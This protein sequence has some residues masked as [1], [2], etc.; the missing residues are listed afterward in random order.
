MHATPILYLFPLVQLML[1]QPIGPAEPASNPPVQS[2]PT[3]SETTPPEA[4][5]A[6][7][8]PTDPGNTD[9]NSTAQTN[10]GLSRLLDE[11]ATNEPPAQPITDP[12]PQ[13]TQAPNLQTDPGSPSTLLNA[14]NTEQ[15]PTEAEPAESLTPP[16][17]TPSTPAEWV[18]ALRAN[19]KDSTVPGMLL[20]VGVLIMMFVM[21]RRLARRGTKHPTRTI[22]P[23]EHIAGIHDRALSSIPPLERSVANAEETARR[24]SAMLDN[25]A[26][27]LDLLI[28]EADTK[29]TQLNAA[30]AQVARNTPVP[31]PTSNHTLQQDGHDSP[32]P[33]Q[34]KIDPSLLDRARVE[35][36]RAERTIDEAYPPAD[37]SRARAARET[38]P[39][40]KHGE[41]N[42]DHTTDTPTKPDPAHR[43]IW[44]LSDDGLPPIEI[45]RTLNQPVGQIELILNLRNNFRR[46]G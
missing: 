30:I 29:L 16:M 37:P 27:R 31:N 13:P 24:I 42:P 26:D 18:E 12:T 40:R 35:Q 17:A 2:A 39:A 41:A 28:Q 9:R 14:T 45:A 7:P 25:K 44:E 33:A 32:R 22:D 4:N 46:S 36:D 10:A 3:K 15:P 21:M 1:A 20:A 38:S 5:Q 43:R 8:L 19:F 6:E 11:A 23:A 34:R